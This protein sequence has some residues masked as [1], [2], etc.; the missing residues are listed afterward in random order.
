VSAPRAKVLSLP[1][2]PKD[3]ARP[4]VRRLTAEIEIDGKT[5]IV[6]VIHD[7]RG[8]RAIASDGATKGP[9]VDAAL[10]AFSDVFSRRASEHPEPAADGKPKSLATRPELKLALD[11]LVT[12]TVRAG[13]ESAKQAPALK[14]ALDS[15]VRIAERETAPGLE[16][17]I[18]RLRNA[19]EF[20]DVEECAM[21]LGGATQLIADLSE[22]EPSD[23]ALE[24]LSGWIQLPGSPP[25]EK[26]IYE[27][28]FVEMGREWVAGVTRA[29]LQ[30][31]YLVDVATGEVFREITRAGRRASV[32]PSP[33]FIHAG[34]ALAYAGTVPTRLQL[35]QYEIAAEVP[36]VAKNAL[37]AHAH[38]RVAELV[39]RFRAAH[40]TAPGQ[41]EPF[42]LF[43]PSEVVWE[44]GAAALL[45]E[46]GM[47]LPLASSEGLELDS[48]LV[49]A[50]EGRVPRLVAGR[51]FLS[52]GVLLLRPFSLLVGEGSAARMVRL[53]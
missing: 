34:L 7:E 37:A 6:A 31:R 29:S 44:D 9:Y 16:R 48:A 51:L 43:A 23:R 27:H 19:I 39:E 17:F 42:A 13:I 12:A 1:T 40:A 45:D 38:R 24:R 22:D 50:L 53:R 11:E 20:G 8:I 46:A 10:E 25:R 15:L 21:L 35:M 33:R 47:R 30:R 49:R 36:E 28:D 18:G 3:D 32:G 52:D 5:E 26:S 14:L 41:A 2:T 4:H